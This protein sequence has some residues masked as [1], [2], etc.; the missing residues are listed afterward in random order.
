MPDDTGTPQ[1][2]MLDSNNDPKLPSPP[3]TGQCQCGAI[4]YTCT[5]HPLALYICHCLSCQQQS[6]SAFGMSLAVPSG[7]IAY[8]T[9]SEEYVGR[10]YRTA[11]S[12]SERGGVFCKCCGVRLWHFSGGEGVVVPD[13]I[14]P[15]TLDR[16]VDARCAVHIWTKRMLPGMVVPEG[17]EM[18]DEEPE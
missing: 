15:G 9:K 18:Y 11:D 6:G 3:L 16:K 10:T 12:G 7:S 17:A 14:K 8:Q 5:S 2:P 4:S 1:K 13:T